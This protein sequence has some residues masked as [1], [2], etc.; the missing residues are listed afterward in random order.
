MLLT[1]AIVSGG[2]LAAV[3]F[4]SSAQPADADPACSPDPFTLA[5]II[6]AATVGLAAWTQEMLRRSGEVT[7]FVGEFVIKMLARLQQKTVLE[8]TEWTNDLKKKQWFK[9][10]IR[11][12]FWLI[13]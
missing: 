5:A 9:W 8:R 6:Q 7:G 13:V 1:M 11:R 2:A 12:G 4:A 10:R 3:F